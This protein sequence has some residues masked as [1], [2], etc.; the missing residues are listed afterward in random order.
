MTSDDHAKNLGRLMVNLQSLE[1]ALRA[2]LLKHK[3]GSEPSGNL[4]NLTVGDCVPVNSFTSYASLG[5]LIEEFN[6]LVSQRHSACR[7]DPAVVDT[8]DALAHGRVAGK[9]LEGPMELLKFGRRKPTGQGQ[10]KCVPVTHA[11]TMD[12]QWFDQQ[13][14]F[15]HDQLAKV[16]EASKTMGQGVLSGSISVRA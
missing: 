16:C 7:V 5:E 15:V 14:T 9:G 13:I 6:K 4:E 8:R 12:K 1:F 10:A 3:E 11:V 2:V